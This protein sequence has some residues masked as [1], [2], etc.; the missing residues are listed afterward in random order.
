M[1]QSGCL[2]GWVGVAVS[3]PFS[4][5]K[6]LAFPKSYSECK[7]QCTLSE[8]VKP[9]GREDWNISS[10]PPTAVNGGWRTTEDM[11]FFS[12]TSTIFNFSLQGTFQLL[13]GRDVL[14]QCSRDLRACRA[15]KPGFSVVFQ[16]KLIPIPLTYRHVE[17]GMEKSGCVCARVSVHKDSQRR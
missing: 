17:F 9:W 2:A 14:R 4:V 16:L 13:G 10:K 15:A 8:L 7:P 11:I 5:G 1:G 12:L 3:L 6:K